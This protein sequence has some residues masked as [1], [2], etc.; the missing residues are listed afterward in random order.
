M[1]KAQEKSVP[2]EEEKDLKKNVVNIMNPREK[3]KKTH[4]KEKKRGWNQGK[5]TGGKRVICME[6]GQKNE[7]RPEEEGVCRKKER[8]VAGFGGE[9]FWKH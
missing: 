4:K 6:G 2:P 1:G 9:K 7:K 3:K 8:G 5:K